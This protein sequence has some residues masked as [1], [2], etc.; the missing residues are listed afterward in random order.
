MPVCLSAAARWLNGAGGTHKKLQII[1]CRKRLLLLTRHPNA[2]A[3]LSDGYA[4]Q[5]EH[6]FTLRMV[7]TGGG[8][9]G[10]VGAV[11]E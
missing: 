5:K 11:C 1:S 4:S 9:G 3:S 8:G 10:A 6:G 7:H 2:V